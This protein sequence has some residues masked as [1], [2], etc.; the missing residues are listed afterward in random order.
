MCFDTLQKY[1]LQDH[2]KNGFVNF[3]IQKAF[4]GL[5]QAGILANKL[6]KQHLAPHVA[7][8]LHNHQVCGASNNQLHS[9]L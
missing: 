3:E 2:K 5:S 6:F 1:Q 8:R 4:H 9:P 7:M